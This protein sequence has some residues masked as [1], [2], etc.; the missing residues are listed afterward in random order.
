MALIKRGIMSESVRMKYNNTEWNRSLFPE[1]HREEEIKNIF[2]LLN[3][4]AS[5]NKNRHSVEH[6]LKS[7]ETC[8]NHESLSND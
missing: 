2:I 6:N 5:Q 3:C 7:C 4:L 1:N 8:M